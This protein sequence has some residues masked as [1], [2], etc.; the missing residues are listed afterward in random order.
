MDLNVPIIPGIPDWVKVEFI[1]INGQTSFTLPSVAEDPDSYVLTVNGVEY[2]RNT[3]FLISGTALTWLN[4]FLL[5]AG[6][7]VLVAYSL[8][9]D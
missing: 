5:V 6:D 9:A 7:R 8:L 4:P 1:A 2:A 3:D